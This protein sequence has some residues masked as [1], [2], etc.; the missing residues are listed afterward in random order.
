MLW[1]RHCISISIV[2]GRA[3]EPMVEVY[4]RGKACTIVMDA[5]ALGGVMTRRTMSIDVFGWGV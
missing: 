4:D 3:G 5:A 1:Q 2:K